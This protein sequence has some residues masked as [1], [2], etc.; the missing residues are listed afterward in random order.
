M[1]LL[2]V[3]K[4]RLVRIFGLNHVNVKCELVLSVLLL[5]RAFDQKSKDLKP[6]H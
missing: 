2:T 3:Q 6:C 4:I 1:V 5:H